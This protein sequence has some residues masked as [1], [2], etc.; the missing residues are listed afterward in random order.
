MKRVIITILAILSVAVCLGQCPIQGNAKNDKE[1]IANKLKNR[2]I[3]SAHIDTTITLRKILHKGED[4]KRFNNNSYVKLTG[5]LVEIKP[6]GKESC[7]CGASIDSLTDTHIYIGTTPSSEKSDCMI[8]EITPR[9][10][11]LNKGLILQHM[12]GKEVIIEGYLFYDEEHKG[13]A[14][15]TCK[16]CTNTWR[17]TCWEIHPVYSIRSAQ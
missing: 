13:N 6:G 16:V 3:V 4:S 15:N 5:Y 2:E 7:N 11:K 9:F 10:K 12:K 14:V 1:V 8:I 17:R